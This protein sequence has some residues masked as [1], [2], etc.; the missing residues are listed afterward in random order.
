MAGAGYDLELVLCQSQSG[1]RFTH[2]ILRNEL[3]IEDFALRKQLLRLVQV[4]LANSHSL[5]FSLYPFQSSASC[6][7]I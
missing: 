3:R 5:A 2:F 7:L 4:T 1:Y 6:A